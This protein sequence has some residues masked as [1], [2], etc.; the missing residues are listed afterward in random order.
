MF[1]KAVFI[2]ALAGI[3]ART[4]R[5]Q[6]RS[7]YALIL[8]KPDAK[9]EQAPPGQSSST[10]SGH[11]TMRATATS[12][13]YFANMLA[14]E[15]NQPVQDMTGLTGTCNLKLDWSPDAP[16]SDTDKDFPSGPSLFTAIQE[17]LGLKL[18]AQK[19]AVEVL[20]VASVQKVP[21]EN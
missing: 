11:G 1:T 17:Q 3:S 16:P 9:L 21:A 19:V 18:R 2:L 15:L 13:A 8:A 4:E 10:S 20:V 12:I 7:A 14:R 6:A 5:S